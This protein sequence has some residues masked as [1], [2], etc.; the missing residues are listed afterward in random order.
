MK[1]HSLLFTVLLLA[2]VTA[3][4]ATLTPYR[5][6]DWKQLIAERRGAPLIVHFW[7]MTCGP[8]L[9]ELPKWS[10]FIHEHRDAKVVFIEVDQAP[11]QVAWKILTN[12]KLDGADNRATVE[13]FD[14]YMRFEI[15]KRWLGELPITMLIAA[16]G[17]A[18]RLDGAVDFASVRSWL[19][20]EKAAPRPK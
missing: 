9:V 17:T 6:G 15:D 8:C 10:A 5:Q 18:T 20:R 16:D 1:F 2:D 11:E 19:S 3:V 12:A 14:E 4:A 7:G 13:Q